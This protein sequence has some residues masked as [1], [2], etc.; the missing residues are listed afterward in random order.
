[1]QT[2]QLNLFSYYNESYE[3][4]IA[5]LSE[6]KFNEAKNAL[7]VVLEQN[8]EDEDAGR[9]LEL[10]TFWQAKTKHCSQLPEK[11]AV[12]YFHGALE[13]FHFT[14]S[15]TGKVL[16][17]ALKLFGLNLMMKAD[18]FELPPGLDMAELSIEI[19]KEP[20]VIAYL[21]KRLIEKPGDAKLHARLADL[22]WLTDDI[23]AARENYTMALLSAHKEVNSE[24]I[25]HENL[26]K[27]IEKHGTEMACAYACLSGELPFPQYDAVVNKKCLKVCK[28]V[29]KEINTTDNREETLK[30]RKQL[31]AT[32]EE[33][34]KVFMQR[35][36][37]IKKYLPVIK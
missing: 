16:H 32:D 28:L 13:Q 5:L 36:S 26:K 31:K 11:E 15:A 24:K 20:L 10:I 37:F 9:A 1:M 4:G 7:A 35:K 30:L 25:K 2:N 34:F 22:Q 19:N 8:P 18:I 21:E 29:M 12:N 17:R 3:K 6:L 23:G 33:F 14:N 27:I